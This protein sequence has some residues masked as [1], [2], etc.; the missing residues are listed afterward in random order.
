MGL[1]IRS[2]TAE[3]V[4]HPSDM[5]GVHVLVVQILPWVQHQKQRC[6]P[7]LVFRNGPNGQ[8]LLNSP[9]GKVPW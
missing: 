3:G 4:N 5:L 8:L 1:Q 7:F 9:L 2:G 6:F